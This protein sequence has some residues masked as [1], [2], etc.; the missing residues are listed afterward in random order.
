MMKHRHIGRYKTKK[1]VIKKRPIHP[2]RR[3]VRK[4]GVYPEDPN[5]PW[6]G[7]WKG[8]LKRQRAELKRYEDAGDGDWP[9]AEEL[10][11]AI[12]VTK[13]EIKIKRNKQ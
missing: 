8:V 10:R 7:G 5:Y 9:E 1:G 6:G 2:I 12:K 4:A 3:K 13:D 11:N